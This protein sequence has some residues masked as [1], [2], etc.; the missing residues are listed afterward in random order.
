MSF[1]KE[2]P[3][4]KDQRKQYRDSRQF[5]RTCRSHGSCS[6]CVEG[7]QHK[8]QRDADTQIKEYLM[9][10]Q[11]KH[12]LKL[13]A[14]ALD[15]FEQLQHALPVPTNDTVTVNSRD[16]RLAV[17]DFKSILAEIRRLE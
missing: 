1:D 13:Q 5:D 4:R 7:R 8:Q 9:R 17:D 11:A 10:Y 16:I 2:Y 3:N 12:I 6:Y 15:C 14:K